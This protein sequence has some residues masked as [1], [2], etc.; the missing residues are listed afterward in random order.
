MDK[1]QL[2]LCLKRFHD[3][4]SSCIRQL[5]NFKT[6]KPSNT[7][8]PQ[9][10]LNTC[11]WGVGVSV[12]SLHVLFLCCCMFA[13]QRAVGTVCTCVTHGLCRL[14]I[15]HAVGSWVVH[16]V[17]GWCMRVLLGTC[18]Y[19]ASI[20]MLSVSMRSFCFFTCSHVLS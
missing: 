15:S 11:C 7:H 4:A 5:Y 20:A 10:V 14:Y 12:S 16:V 13:A 2:K 3:L 9:P 1:S 19:V 17:R 8:L 6:E 18:F